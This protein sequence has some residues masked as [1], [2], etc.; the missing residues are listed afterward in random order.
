MHVQHPQREG[1]NECFWKYFSIGD[2]DGVVTFVRLNCIHRFCIK[3][4]GC[5]HFEVMCARKNPRFGGC[6]CETPPFRCV[7]SGHDQRGYEALRNEECKCVARNERRTK[8][9]EGMRLLRTSDM[10]KILGMVDKRMPFK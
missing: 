4:F 7:R 1:M 9:Y 10:Y 5:K 8:K 2:D 3:R 6:K